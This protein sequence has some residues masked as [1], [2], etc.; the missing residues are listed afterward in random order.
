MGTDGI[1]RSGSGSFPVLR[2]DLEPPST[3]KKDAEAAPAGA[4][5]ASSAPA[6]PVGTG[7]ANIPGTG[8][9]AALKIRG[10]LADGGPDM[11]A[12]SGFGGGPGPAPA[13]TTEGG[14]RTV[15]Q[16]FQA[17]KKRLTGS[18][19]SEGYV[20]S[21]LKVLEA[22]KGTKEFDQIIDRLAKETNPETG[23]PLLDTFVDNAAEDKEQFERLV[24]L[25]APREGWYVAP[26]PK[27][28][29]MLSIA[30]NVDEQRSRLPGTLERGL[31]TTGW[32]LQW[33]TNP[34]GAAAGGNVV[35]LEEKRVRG[36]M[37]MERDAIYR[38]LDTDP[39]AILK[40]FGKG[41]PSNQDL[42][43]L[44]RAMLA[45]IDG[46]GNPANKRLT[47]ILEK[48]PP[49]EIP[50][51]QWAVAAGAEDLGVAVSTRMEGAAFSGVSVNSGAVTWEAGE[52]IKAL[53]EKGARPYA[54]VL[55]N[56]EV[57][58]NSLV[59]NEDKP[60]SQTQRD[61]YLTVAKTVFFAKD[62]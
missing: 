31:G 52:L 5:D 54:V 15:E 51:L 16:D 61:E 1:Q 37:S 34:G 46:D 35:D 13:G 27:K 53:N 56:L 2:T 26:E 40:Q 38:I 57:N 20:A 44:G 11:K 9:Y 33:I 60:W 6:A 10:Q 17:I 48:T 29:V 36:V 59:H 19:V 50:R 14:V 41:A 4:D 18:W 30:R 32:A 42:R 39:G 47:E 62:K 43:P 25:V 45:E 21:S 8:R 22:R 58:F 3:K 24:N 12:L 7:D 49:R 28:A 55:Q 23:K